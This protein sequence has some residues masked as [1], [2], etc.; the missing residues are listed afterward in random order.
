RW[1]SG[2]TK[3]KAMAPVQA[4]R[5]RSEE[6][7]RGPEMRTSLPDGTRCPT[8]FR[9]LPIP[10]QLE[11]AGEPSAD[12]EST[13]PGRARIAVAAPFQDEGFQAS[14]T[15][16]SGRSVSIDSGSRGNRG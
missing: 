6:P 2:A 15:C 11:K 7:A 9:K 1:A 14:P 13:L 4:R 10:A 8:R 16:F 3:A 5:P 12:V